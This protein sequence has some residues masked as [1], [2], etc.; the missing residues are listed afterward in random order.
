M[1]TNVGDNVPEGDTIFRAAATLRRALLQQ[2][3]TAARNRVD[4]PALDQLVGSQIVNIE[5]RGKHLL[6]HFASTLALHSHMGMT[7][8]WHVYRPG[9]SWYK[10]ERQAAV[11]LQT[12][13]TTCVCF[14][15]KTI[16]LLTAAELRRHRYLGRL[17][18]D[19][20]AVDLERDER[21]W[22]KIEQRFR[23]ANNRPIGTAI[24]DQTIVCGVGNVYKSEV[25]FQCRIDPFARVSTLDTATLRAMLS[26][27]QKLMA[28]NLSGLPRKTRFGADGVRLWVYGRH[29]EHCLV[30]GETIQMRRQGDLGRSTYWCPECQS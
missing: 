12:A 7:G 29:G 2:I 16:E 20:L 22:N 30:C 21:L 6:I 26:T 15:P 5:A 11:M 1:S 9:Q 24:M 19:L 10:P 18:P 3:V 14:S 17:G 4:A 28:R 27:A 13:H 8:A 25:L 23:V